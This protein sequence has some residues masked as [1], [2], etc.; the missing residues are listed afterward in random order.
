[1]QE[2]LPDKTVA[3]RQRLSDRRPNSREAAG[4]S[5]LLGSAGGSRLQRA[6]AG[7]ALPRRA[8]ITGRAAQEDEG[9]TPG[10]RGRAR[11]PRA[12]AHRA[13]RRAIPGVSKGPPRRQEVPTR[14]P[15]G[16]HLR[17]EAPTWGPERPD[18]ASR[19][20]Y[21]RFRGAPAG[22]ERAA[23]RGPRE[24]DEVGRGLA[25]ICGGGRYSP[26]GPRHYAE[27]LLRGA[28]GRERSRHVGS[29]EPAGKRASAREAGRYQEA[30]RSTGVRRRRRPGTE[31]T[32][33]AGRSHRQDVPTARGGG[34]GSDL[35][36]QH[37]PIRVLSQSACSRALGGKANSSSTKA[38]KH[39]SKL[40]KV[41]SATSSL[42]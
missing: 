33:T 38:P 1:M 22:E 40:F 14:R 4:R 23:G 28:G 13:S 26:T 8:G 9:R 19:G 11:H 21:A 5:L 41:F 34:S 15:E 20:P 10:V 42:L 17:G 16:P 37:G 24:E 36:Q 3:R 31:P 7:R 25:G 6:G 35:Q 2:S 39:Y 18:S 12:E 27:P 30:T 32:R 29:W